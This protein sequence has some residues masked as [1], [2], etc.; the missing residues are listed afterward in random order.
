MAKKAIHDAVI[1]VLKQSDGGLSIDQILS[2]IQSQGLYQFN[3][4]DPRGVLSKAIRRRTLSSGSSRVDSRIAPVFNRH[5]G[6]ITL[7]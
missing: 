2:S 3:T 1:E 7:L 5:A 6:R 4:K